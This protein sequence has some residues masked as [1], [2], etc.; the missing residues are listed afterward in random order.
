MI[1]SRGWADSL[2]LAEGYGLGTFVILYGIERTRRDVRAERSASGSGAPSIGWGSERQSSYGATADACAPTRC[3]ACKRGRACPDPGKHP[4]VIKGVQEHG[5][6]DA[7]GAM[8][9]CALIA[10]LRPRPINL[11]IVPAAHVLVLDVDP[12]NG[13]VATLRSLEA[14][15]G[16]LPPTLGVYT[17]RCRPGTVDYSE[18]RWWRL[19]RPVGR[20][21][22]AIGPGLDIKTSG[23]LL[24]APPSVHLDGWR[25]AWRKTKDRRGGYLPPAECPTWLDEI[26]RGRETVSGGAIKTRSAGR[27]QL[28]TLVSRM[29]RA[30]RGEIQTELFNV[31]CW[32]YNTGND[33]GPIVDAARGLGLTEHEI[34]HQVQGA[35]RATR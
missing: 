25:Y 3:C 22:S 7:R 1:V 8:E 17:G 28:G 6:L 19:P 11:G 13:G 23:G 18:H 26:T 29:A 12:R 5:H 33:I 15:Y 14:R 10:T 35:R 24:V 30:Q 20:R 2:A 9:I 27:A 32:A 31:A 21:V 34:R 4:M 16:P